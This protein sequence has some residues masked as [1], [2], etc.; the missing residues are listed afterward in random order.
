MAA[1]TMQPKRPIKRR[2]LTVPCS[3]ERLEGRRLLSGNSLVSPLLGH[4]IGYLA[5]RPNTPVMPFA[6]PAKKATYIDPSVKIVNGTTIVLGYQSFIGPY[7]TLDG[8][9]GAIKVGNGSDVLDNATI[10]ASGGR[11]RGASEVLIGDSVVI[12]FGAKVLGP[13]TIGAYGSASQPTSIGAN[14]V[15]DGA[16][17]QAGAIVSPLARVAPGVTV[18]AGYRVLP[19]ANVT[20][21]QEASKPALGMVVKVTA[22]DVSTIEKTLSENESLASGY[23]TLYQ[24]QSATGANPA[25]SPA[26]TGINNGNLA[27]TW[28]PIRSLDRRRR[29][30]SRPR[31]HPNSCPLTWGSCRSSRRPFRRG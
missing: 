20:T 14:A 12:G 25:A 31:A 17:I 9:K 6:S 23:V 24:G 22:S 21:N 8:S 4:P 30:S 16:T 1:I 15:I 2:P 7:A 3:V 26:L 27:A 10:V 29:R 18:P 5:T 19:G 13:S 28:E 11:E